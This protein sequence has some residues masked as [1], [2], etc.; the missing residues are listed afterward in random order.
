MSK[1]ETGYLVPH[2]HW[3]REWRY[4]IWQNRVLLIEFMEQLLN[5]LD[6]D[7]GY[8]TFVLDGQSVI[9]EDYLEVRPQDREKVCK[10]IK[11]G[12]ISI[13]PWYTLPDQYPVCGESLVRNLLKGIRYSSSL[14]GYLKVGY[15]SFGWGQTAQLPQIY[16]GFGLNFI[17]T[18]KYVSEKRAPESEFL[19]EALDGTRVLTTKLGK[20][21]RHSF[22]INSY[23]YIMQNAHCLAPGHRLEWEKDAGVIFHEADDAGYCKDYFKLQTTAKIH[24]GN[25]SEGF[26]VA[27]ENTC[28]TTVKAHRLLLSGCDFTGPQPLLTE[29]IKK[30][31]ENLDDKEFISST[32]EDYVQKLKETIDENS[33]KVVKGE[34]RDGNSISCSG[35]ALQTRSYIKRLNKRVQDKLFYSAEP[36]SVF[37]CLAGARYQTEFLDLAL[38]Y[39][40]QSQAHDS[41]NGVTQ[42]KTARDT[43]YRLEQA[44]EIS[45]C[46]SNTACGELIKRMELGKYDAKDVLLVIF[47]PALRKRREITKVWIDTPREQNIWDIDLVDSNGKKIDIQHIS[48]KEHGVN[49]N[50]FDSRPWPF[51]THRHCAYMDTGELPAGGYKV[52]KVV[53]KAEMSWIGQWPGVMRKNRGEDIVKTPNV[54]ENK[55]LN[56]TVN[57]NGTV[58]ILDKSTQERYENLNYYEDTGDC[59]DYWIYFPPYNNKTFTSLGCTANIWMEDN[60]PL[61]ATIVAGIK[62]NLPADAI[63]PESGIAGE[64]R[65]DDAT[66]ELNIVTYYTLNRDSKRLDVKV[67]VDNT[68]E[69]H[70]FRVMFNTGIKSEYSYAAGHFNVDKRVIPNLK[71]ESSEY[72]PEMQTLPQQNF[73]DVSDGKCGFAIINNCLSEFEAVNN[74]SGTLAITLFRSVRNRICTE[75]IWA[76]FPHEKGGQSLGEQE[77]EYS[78]YPHE[79]YW[80]D[81]GVY[82]ESEKFNVPLKMVQTSKH[83]GGYL[84][85]EQE[86]LSIQP[87]NLIVTALKK[88]EDRD[89]IILRIF[90]PADSTIT[91]KISSGMEIKE[92][93]LTN[94]DEERQEKIVV[95]Q[96]HQII[97]EAA[98][99]KIITIELNLYKGEQS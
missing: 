13:G 19:W 2:T 78:I 18:A 16:K 42:D 86:F 27:W 25:I 53:P 67:K 5:I 68:V 14:G 38:K 97:L 9:I 34:L 30:A 1:K 94:L 66:K 77:Y 35:N 92:A 84:P 51:Y 8:K 22:F 81:A 20:A 39:M 71:E 72:Y 29:L 74:E 64:S 89:S 58:S 41:I 55:F 45:E 4:P 62:L 90:N 24:E 26:N 23:I 50:D 33:L 7:P 40:L 28:E 93:Y 80:N 63:R 65:R 83:S 59:G 43:V 6:T 12:R 79:G 76:E 11:E 3:D 31:N 87:S 49:V 95:E 36:L 61:S 85:A 70:R 88:A 48:R 91:G 54:L 98:S 96:E 52:F 47:N 46:V 82:N 57:S 60:G 75:R 21:G 73:I 15:T 56:V 10:Y 69:D 17:V 99:N 37:G 32:L 44:L